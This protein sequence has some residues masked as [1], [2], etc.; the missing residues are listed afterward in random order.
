MIISGMFVYTANSEE[1]S[2]KNGGS[3]QTWI[4]LNDFSHKN[5]FLDWRQEPQP[6]TP[7]NQHNLISVKC[8][9]QPR[10]LVQ[11]MSTSMDL[12]HIKPASQKLFIQSMPTINQ[13]SCYHSLSPRTLLEK[14]PNI[15]FDEHSIVMRPPQRQEQLPV[16]NS[17]CTPPPPVE[18]S[19]N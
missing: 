9:G 19:L 10:D 2:T 7:F 8:V 17:L 15:D 6:S 14:L 3:G 16:G 18:G 13:Q 1:K 12:I 11:E 4:K 5:P